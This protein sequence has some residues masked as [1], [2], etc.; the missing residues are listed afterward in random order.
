MGPS[1]CA[2]CS[3]YCA[4]VVGRADGRAGHLQRLLELLRE[5]K[6]AQ[7]RAS[8]PRKE[9]VLS[10]CMG[11]RQQGVHGAHRQTVRPEGKAVGLQGVD[12]RGN[13]GEVE[14]FKGWES[15]GNGGEVEGFKGWESRGDG[16]EVEGMGV[17][18]R[19]SREWTV[20]GANRVDSGDAKPTTGKPLCA[21]LQKALRRH[22]ACCCWSHPTAACS[23]LH[24]ALPPPNGSPSFHAPPQSSRTRMVALNHRVGSQRHGYMCNPVPITNADIYTAA[25]LVAAKHCGSFSTSG[26]RAK[27]D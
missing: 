13:G 11:A 3:V 5:A 22:A 9:H 1:V 6:V 19:D 26:P 18:S 8:V 12:S 23:L 17:K 27:S 16:G 21:R 4:H 7:H 2:A 14:G 20:E 25:S 24:K 15:R 10:L